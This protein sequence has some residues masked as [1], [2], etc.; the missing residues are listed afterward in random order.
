MI[1][2]LSGAQGGGKTSLLNE[3]K[4]RGY[5]V[6]DFKVSRYVQAKF[7][8]TNLYEV[9]DHPDTMKAFQEEVFKCKLKNDSQFVD[10]VDYVLTERTFADIYAYTFSWMHAF[11]DRGD[12]SEA[13]GLAWLQSYYDRCIEAQC[14]IYRGCLLLPMMQHISFENDPHRA[15][16][17]SVEEVFETISRFAERCAFRG[18][19]RLLISQKSVEDR[20]TEVQQ[21]LNTIVA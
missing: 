21:F 12:V 8:W 10:T 4:T 3:L 5:R 20:A 1:I 9:L 2:G 7:G 18:V 19:K 16:S 17:D 15:K 14:Q 11:I 13:D 6:D